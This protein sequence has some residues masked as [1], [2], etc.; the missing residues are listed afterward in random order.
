MAKVIRIPGD[1]FTQD[2][3]V[4]GK[5]PLAPQKEAAWALRDGVW[6]ENILYPPSR[7][8]HIELRDA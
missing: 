5:G 1:T 7:I 2:I 6:V 8:V 3:K 4:I